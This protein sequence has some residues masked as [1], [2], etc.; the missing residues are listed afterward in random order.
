MLSGYK[1]Y[2]VASLAVL[3]ALG[4]WLDGDLTLLAALNLAVPALLAMTVR[5]GIAS[6]GA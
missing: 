6:T 3:G 4:G 5:H 2:I 1:T